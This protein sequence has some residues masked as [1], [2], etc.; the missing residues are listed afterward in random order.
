MAEEKTKLSESPSNPLS[1]LRPSSPANE[2]VIMKES[3]EK[4][5][6]G[7]KDRN[8]PPVAPQIM[9]KIF[10]MDDIAIMDPYH[11]L[12]DPNNPKVSKYLKDE[13]AYASNVMKHTQHLQDT[14][15]EEF[16][17]RTQGLFPFCH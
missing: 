16:V 8:A 11:W 2:F 14:L 6:G 1:P 15:Y 5:G 3:R 12:R 10:E 17:K 13:N 9:E 4:E 7:Q